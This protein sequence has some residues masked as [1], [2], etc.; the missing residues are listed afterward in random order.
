MQLL[1]DRSYED[2][3]YEGLGVIPG[4]VIRFQAEPGLKIPH[5]GWNSLLFETP[6]PLLKG[7]V[8]G[9]DVYFVHSYHVQP[10]SD[11]VILTRTQH[12]SQTFAS[13]V[14]RGNVYAAQFH[15]EKSQKIGLKILKNFVEMVQQPAATGA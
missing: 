2:G 7:L 5:M 14:H 4:T 6:H 13:M 3:D 1:F 9:D 11:D 8:S 15:P 12:G 10:E